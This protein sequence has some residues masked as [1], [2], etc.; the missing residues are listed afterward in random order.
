MDT[1]ITSYNVCYTKLLR[2]KNPLNFVN[3]FSDV[4]AEITDEIWNELQARKETLPADFV[5]ELS[6]MLEG[7]RL[8]SQKVAEHGKRADAI[9]QNMLL[10][11]TSYSIHYT[12]LY[13]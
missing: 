6:S 2:I 10:V 9:V 11:I 12:K 4:S 3:N 5:D 13:D 8:N 1:R 7:L